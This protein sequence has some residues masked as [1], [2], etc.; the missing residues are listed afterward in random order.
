[1]QGDSAVTFAPKLWLAMPKCLRCQTENPE[2][3]H[4]CLNCGARLTAA[5]RGEVRKTVTVLFTDV[6]DSTPLGEK[7]DPESLRRVMSLYFESMR[8]VLERHGGTIEKFIGD[9]VMAVFGIPVLHEDDALRAVRAAIEMQS[10]L[11]ALN[12]HLRS[13]WGVEIQM[14]TGINT[15]EVV[16]GDPAAGE[17]LVIGDPVNVAARL[18]QTAGPGEVL[19]GGS[20]FQLVRDAV[21]AEAVEPLT[22]KGK[23]LP[24]QAHRVHAVSGDLQGRMRRLDSAVVG[25]ER[26]LSLLK[27]ALD[28]A[29]GERSCYLF[30]VLGPAGVGKSRLVGEFLRGVTQRATV[31]RGRCVA[32]GEGITFWPLREAVREAVGGQDGD[33]IE[34]V[35]TRINDLLSADDDGGSIADRLHQVLGGAQVTASSDELF[36]AAR[37]FLEIQAAVRPLIIVF[38]DIHWAEPTFLDLIEHITDWSR[39]APILLLSI[40]RPELLDGRPSWGGGKLNATSILLEPLGTRDSERLMANLLGQAE[41]EAELGARVVE[42]AEGNPLFI[43]EMISMLIDEGIL[44]LKDGRWQATSA[45]SDISTPP[46]VQALL[47]TRLE[48][49]APSEREVAARAAVIGRVFWREAASDLMSEEDR[50]QVADA[51]MA[52]IRKEIIRPDRSSFQ[53]QDAFRFRH[54]L[55][56]DAAYSA[57]PKESR[58]ELHERFASWLER[59]AANRLVEFEEILGYHYEQAYRYRA[60]LGLLDE[61][62]RRLGERAAGLLSSAG[63]RARERADYPAAA[64]LLRR[65]LEVLP[66]DSARGIEPATTLAEVLYETGEMDGAKKVLAD[67]RDRLNGVSD[68]GLHARVNVE[69]WILR[70][71][72]EPG[73]A[74]S[75]AERAAQEAIEIFESDGKV[76]GLTRAYRLLQWVLITEE[77]HG[78][79]AKSAEQSARCA[80]AAGHYHDADEALDILLAAM[81]WGPTPVAEAIRRFTTLLEENAGRRTAVAHLQRSLA[82]LTAKR[83]E[84]D[85]ARELLGESDRVFLE[86]GRAMEHVAGIGLVG[87]TIEML[88]QDWAAAEAIGRRTWDGLLGMGEKGIASTAGGMLALVLA[89]QGKANEAIELADAAAE[90]GSAN[91]VATQVLTRQ[92]KAEGLTT[93]GQLELAETVARQAVSLRS[94]TDNIDGHGDALI[95]LAVVL[96]RAGR[97]AEAADTIRQALALFEQKGNLA[98]LRN[99]QA[100]L[101]RLTAGATSE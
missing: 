78:R 28:R 97:I 38:D 31:I 73:G 12:S 1:M 93:I 62:A 41:A 95:T 33:D 37:R 9:A 54:A 46:T 47:A 45:I 58:G 26:E 57:L 20:T 29:I 43:E 70:L 42:A 40:A 52:L 8:T 18:E 3:A 80:R 96:E 44:Q 49:L 17:T 19:I 59:V 99:G 64:K 14:R 24:V 27:Q 10:E 56:R 60:E 76:F 35:T 16:A 94:L 23:S 89:R 66:Q 30:T 100:Q 51:L 11:E 79:L 39:D 85:R 36:W 81:V 71:L 55:I 21:S 69:E 82:F 50:P 77:D 72:L 88:A 7:L 2:Q 74:E 22:L 4:F 75:E 86:Q 63:L 68:R 32:Y 5:P 90:L 67:A 48:L 34:T 53:G 6:V 92:A 15:G 98:S 87:A 83:L 25:R 13:Q 61:Q 91:D 84:F 101:G 65:T